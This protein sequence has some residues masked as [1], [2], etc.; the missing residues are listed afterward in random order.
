MTGRGVALTYP[1]LY[2]SSGAGKPQAEMGRL[3]VSASPRRPGRFREPEKT[4]LPKPIQRSRSTTEEPWRQAPAHE[5]SSLRFPLTRLS[6]KQ[7]SLHLNTR[8]LHVSPA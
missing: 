7:K 6:G 8:A 1:V 4:H 2:L 5:N 3:R